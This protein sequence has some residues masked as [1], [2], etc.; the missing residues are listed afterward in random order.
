MPFD[1][2]KNLPKPGTRFALPA[3]HGSADAFLL[4]QAARELKSRGQ[5]LAIVVA[6]ASD[7]QRL[8]N[9]MP[10]FRSDDSQ[11]PLRCHL[12]TDWETFP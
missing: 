1:L 4:A 8:L 2:K 7:A 5:M 9:E 3:L 6:N 12:H 10:W 11:E